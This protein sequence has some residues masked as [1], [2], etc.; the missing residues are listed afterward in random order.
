MRLLLDT[1]VL[2]WLLIE[3]SRIPPDTL[4]IVRNAA[5]DIVVSATTPLEL[6]TKERLGRLPGAKPLLLAYDDHLGRFGATE[7]AVTGRQA[8]VAGSLTWDNRDPFDRIIAA[9]SLTEGI[10]L[11]TA[12]AAFESLGAVRTLWD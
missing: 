4:G 8:L 1:H 7:L 12:D 10:H 9:Q 2:L 3:P 11:V 6:A 5:N